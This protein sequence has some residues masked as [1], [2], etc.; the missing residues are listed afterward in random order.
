MSDTSPE[1]GTSPSRAGGRTG[2]LGELE[3]KLE[4]M[5]APF[6]RLGDSLEVIAQRLGFLTRFSAWFATAGVA[7]TCL[8]VLSLLS[9]DLIMAPTLV[10]NGDLTSH[11]YPIHE[12]VTRLL[13]SGTVSGWTHGWYAGIPLYTFYFPLPPL[14]VA[15]LTPLLGFEV[16]VKWMLALGPMLL[17]PATYAFLRSMGLSRW[18]AVS[19]TALGASFLV[20]N[21]FAIFGGNLLS[22]YI[23]EFSYS[24]SFALSL[25][26]LAV[27][28]SSGRRRTDGTLAASALLALTALSHV[29][30]TGMAVAATLP[31]VRRRSFRQTIVRSW[32]LGFLFAAFWAFP[33]LARLG[34]SSGP[35]WIHDPQWSEVFPTELN[36]F[37]PLAAIGAVWVYWRARHLA[38]PL[39]LFPVLAVL[40]H[41]APQELIHRTRWLPYGFFAVHVMAGL[42][43]GAGLERFA[44]RR[45]VLALIGAAAGILYVVGINNIRDVG[46]VK[47][48]VRE[49]VSGYESTEL[50]QEYRE[51]VDRISELP[52]G[53]VFWE[54]TERIKD[55]GSPL[56][57][58]MLPY[59][60]PDHAVLNGLWSESA[61]HY[62]FYLRLSREVGDSTATQV[63]VHIRVPG[64][65]DFDRG[66]EHAKILGA[67][68][69]VGYSE[70][71]RSLARSR[72]DMRPVAE[73]EPWAVFQVDGR[74]VVE[75]LTN[76]P[77]V[78]EGPG[79]QEVATLWFD[80]LYASPTLVSA[81]G[82][83][84][85]ARV[86]ADLSDLGAP[87]PVDAPRGAVS[88]V[89]VGPE[90]ISFRTTA[91]GVPHL[92]RVS[93]FPNWL[94]I[95][96]IGPF[97]V[98]PAFM[99]VIPREE[100]VRLE[101]VDTWTEWAGRGLTLIGLVG[102]LFTTA[103]AGASRR[104]PE[105]RPRYY[106]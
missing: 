49:A 43:I 16:A 34:L 14:V 83:E 5:A 67:G 76:E 97:R 75:P 13:P 101:Y 95:G 61:L 45:S 64:P 60:S 44:R 18:A 47:N 42:A 33:F 6:R 88:D 51:L 58:Q 87:V 17:P 30:T 32:F 89:E 2:R 31:L 55:Y 69:F 77:V 25:F 46:Y 74:P 82:P 70:R 79:F 93:Y 103:G 52:P 38:Y 96:A 71:T 105:Y 65:F 19:G 53:R 15:A 106:G 10:N 12:F 50:A 80:S 37:L 21:S 102:A 99:L 28:L 40:F 11:V 26:Y 92:V 90:M 98:S 73:A 1:K 66:I 104:Q 41:L 7:L 36:V 48:Y 27:V 39:L 3:A 29:I 8:G 59:W 91:V 24:I 22:T 94:A 54:E 85:W 100:E 4:R 86:Q 35:P 20:M 62:P 56:A 9:P 57:L 78:Y 63:T 81:G 23:G 68:Y 72:S 84:A